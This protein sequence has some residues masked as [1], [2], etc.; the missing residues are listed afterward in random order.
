MAL[1]HKLSLTEEYKLRLPWR[2][3][4][5]LYIYSCVIM[6]INNKIKVSKDDGENKKKL[7][8]KRSKIVA[9]MNKV[10]EITNLH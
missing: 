1:L 9:K 8:N 6:D 10:L 3:N 4:N 7:A 2:P 5:W